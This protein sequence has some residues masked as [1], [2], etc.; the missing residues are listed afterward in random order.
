MPL[1]QL[2]FIF[3]FT[4]AFS[5]YDGLCQNSGFENYRSL[6]KED[7]LPS[8][9]IYCFKKDHEGFMWIGTSAGL[10]RYDGSQILVFRNNK[11]D[12]TSISG[13]RVTSISMDGDSI[14]W[15][16]T[17]K[18]G[19]NKF[20]FESQT[21]K[22]YFPNPNKEGA[23]PNEE[24]NI[25]EQ[26]ASGNL[27]IGFH[28]SDICKY[29]RETDSFESIEF[30]I[31]EDDRFTRQSSIP[32]KIAFDKNNNL[33][34]ISTLHHLFRYNVVDKTFKS[35]TFGDK[36]GDN[37]SVATIGR[38]LI[39]ED[40]KIY[41]PAAKKGLIVFDPIRETW[42]NYSEKYFDSKNPRANSYG[43]IEAIDST[44]FWLG[45]R[46]QGLASIDLTKG[47]IV[48]ADSCRGDIEDQLC[49][50]FINCF[51]M[52]EED[53][54]WI[55]TDK[56]LRIYNKIGNQFNV[57]NHSVDVEGLKSRAS[58]RALYKDDN[59]GLYYGG[60]AGEGVYYLDLK[61]NTKQLIKPPKKYQAGASHE[62]FYTKS[63]KQ[64]DDSTLLV[65][66]DNALFKL[67]LKTKKLKEIDIG[68]EFSKD[69]FHLNRMLKHSDGT[70]Y[71]T[72]RYYGVFR[73]DS[74]YSL[75]E[76][77]SK[78]HDNSN[79]LVS[80]GYIY[81]ICEDPDGK[82][83]IG[84]ED[85]FSI[86]NPKTGIYTNSNYVERLDS[87]PQLKIIYSTKLAPDSSV[88]LIDARNNSV[89]VK[90]PY[91]EPFT[92]HTIYTG[93]DSIPERLGNVFFTKDGKSLLITNSGLSIIDQD[94]NIKRYNDK[95]GLPPLNTLGP[96]VEFEDGKIAIGSNKNIIFFYPDS[97]YDYTWE[98]TIYI[99]SIS[100]FNEKHDVNLKHVEE[101]GISLSYEQNYF[102]IGLGMINYNNPEE[103]TLAYRLK[104]L[105]DEW[106]I[107]TDRKAVFTSVPGGDY[108]FEAKLLDRNKDDLKQILS[109]P[110]EIIPP[111]W[112]TLWFKIIGAILFTIIGLAFYFIRIRSIKREEKLKTEFNKQIANM[113]L[114]AL[115]AQMNPHFLFNSLN[116]IRNKIINNDLA[117][118]DKYLVKFSRLVRQVLQNS[119]EQLINL[120]DEM[121]T[122]NLYVDLES[123]RFD[124]RFDYHLNVDKGINLMDFKIPPL[125][126]QPYIENAIWHGLMQ[127]EDKG[128]VT[129]Y[130]SIKGESLNITIEDD[131][132]GREKAKKLKSKTALKHQ[133]MGM[134]ITGNRLEIIEKI[135]QLS[136]HAEIIDLKNKNGNSAGTKVILT[137]P[138]IYE[139]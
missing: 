74:S 10:V 30:P 122:L 73:F 24:V 49:A 71:I 38:M 53:G 72:S 33:V 39:H 126:L 56:G 46:A 76:K 75:I 58:V 127:K 7:G 118:A 111:F 135:Y 51:D 59:K 35:Y 40:G 94:K 13:N 42:K 16:G 20:Y 92:Y 110:I 64:L 136:C 23:L 91:I 101:K 32:R 9:Y 37:S 117:D 50:L 45:G 8:N 66:S 47:V 139:S 2:I 12:S 67:N 62:M 109:M 125:I 63:I 3:L 93:K 57:F 26:D 22:R 116:S 99:S 115:R 4:S 107:N 134:G 98:P 129:I 54:H 103:Y 19:L 6:T 114:S 77:M 90:Y 48:R 97:L 61:T 88:W 80:S 21:F 108:T 105:S 44:R 70:L 102:S 17:G 78:D 18:S 100:I 79:S 34:W 104:G 86:F 52:D 133:S 14:M 138:L 89:F 65:L 5:I 55:G 112:K 137:L 28:R 132:I 130:I 36:P 69:F 1:K 15:V 83:W 41:I 25:L 128:E 121:E 96:M 43:V 31:F 81:E 84:S 85:G 120:N 29:N 123:S 106:I 95:H 27:W 87:I 124:H 131:G 113:E 82:V 60:N 119:T 68:L 11:E